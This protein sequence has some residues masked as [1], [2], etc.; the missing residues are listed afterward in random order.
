LKLSL[1]IEILTAGG[2]KKTL[3]VRLFVAEDLRPV[4]ENQSTDE[5][6]RFLPLA[7]FDTEEFHSA[8][9]PNARTMAASTLTG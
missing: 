7:V 6:L 9:R 5:T 3:F 8:T 2:S 4:P 1:R